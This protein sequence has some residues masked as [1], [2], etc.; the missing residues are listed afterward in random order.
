MAVTARAVFL[1][2]RRKYIGG[3][4]IGAIVGV[5]P[6]SSPLSVYLDKIGES[7]DQAETLPMRRGLYMER[8]IKAE[9]VREHP[10]YVVDLHPEPIVRDDWGFPAGASLDGLVRVRRGT[11]IVGVFEAK[12]TSSWNARAF[13][14]AQGEMPD[15]YFVQCQWYMAVADLPLAWLVVDV[16]ESRLRTVEVPADP[17]VQ[18]RLIN[19]GRDFWAT[20]VLRR[21]PPEPN[22]CERDGGILVTLYP[23]SKPEMAVPLDDKASALALAYEFNRAAAKEAEAKAE[24]AKQKLCAF[25]GDA[26]AA[27]CDGYRLSWKSQETTRLDSKALKEAEPEIWNRYAKTSASRVFRCKGVSE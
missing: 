7:I 11:E 12:T 16:G 15:A 24:E 17:K 14:D 20:H 9:F 18:D 4:D 27:V 10:E 1:E 8:F 2:E 3:T 19:A 22:G 25:M 23:R 21:N 13:D 26:E 6:W 5:S